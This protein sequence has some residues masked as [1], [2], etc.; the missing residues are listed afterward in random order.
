LRHDS[1]ATKIYEKFSALEKDIIEVRQFIENA[2]SV[3]EKRGKLL[4]ADDLKYIAPYEDKLFLGKPSETL[5]NKSKNEI[6][7]T[8]RRRRTFVSVTAIALIIVLSGFTI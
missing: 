5:I 8:R 6:T 7:R 4:T 3:Y 2:F 1:L